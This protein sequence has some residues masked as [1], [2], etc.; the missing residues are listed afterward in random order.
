M[1]NNNFLIYLF[2]F[3][4]YLNINLVVYYVWVAYATFFVTLLSISSS[5]NMWGYPR[6]NLVGNVFSILYW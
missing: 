3:N 6:G 4:I 5:K 1:N 2:I